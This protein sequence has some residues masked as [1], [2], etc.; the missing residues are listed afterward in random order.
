MQPTSRTGPNASMSQ[1][2]GSSIDISGTW[3]AV[4][5]TFLVANYAG[6]IQ[7]LA[8]VSESVLTITQ[9]GNAFTGTALQ[10]GHSMIRSARTITQESP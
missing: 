5:H 2:A 6:A 9:N 8:C 10:H 7:Q 3:H 4:D 1:G